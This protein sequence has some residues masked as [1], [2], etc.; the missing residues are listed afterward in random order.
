MKWPTRCNLFMRTQRTCSKKPELPKTVCEWGLKVCEASRSLR[1]NIQ[2]TLNIQNGHYSEAGDILLPCMKN[3]C[4]FLT[5]EYRLHLKPFKVWIITSQDVKVRVGTRVLN[6]ETE[7]GSILVLGLSSVQGA[8]AS[9]G[10]SWE[11]WGGRV[12]LVVQRQRLGSRPE[13]L[14]LG[15]ICVKAAVRSL[16]SGA[17]VVAVHGIHRLRRNWN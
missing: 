8:L 11:G 5:R 12:W 14:A 4:T 10:G 17:E 1:S 16:W 3:I 7:A 15:N 2:W 9:W 13:L 6:K